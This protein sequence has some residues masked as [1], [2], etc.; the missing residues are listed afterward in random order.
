MARQTIN[1][2]SSPNKGDGDPLRLAFNKINENFDELYQTTDTIA[3]QTNFEGNFTG[4]V[5]ADNSTKLV[6]GDIGLIVG[7][8]VNNSV[9]TGDLQVNTIVA[10]DSTIFFDS[11][12]DTLT[13]TTGIFSTVAG[14]LTGQVSDISNHS[15]TNLSEGTNLY[16]TDERVDDRVSNLIVGGS[17]LTVTYNDTAGTLTFDVSASSTYDSSSFDTDL[18]GKSTSDLSEGTNLYYTTTRAN[19]AIDAR[20][21]NAFVS[22]LGSLSRNGLAIGDVKLSAVD[23]ALGDYV[24]LDGAA[25]STAT[26]PDLAPLMT[27]LPPSY[28]EVTGTPTLADTGRGIFADADYVYIAHSGS[29][30]LTI[31]NRSDFTVVG[32]TPSLPSYGRGVFADADYVYIAHSGSPFLTILNRADFTVVSG[33]PVLPSDGNS[34][35]ADADYVYIAHDD[36]PYLT[37]LNFLDNGFEVPTVASPDPV[38]EYRI[39][40]L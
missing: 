11:A 35:F 13:V 40:A 29:P 30:Y 2:G 1:I 22:A 16:Y 9:S 23:L 14:D 6:D 34:I 8:V 12:S 21:D 20:V 38:L 32:G 24:R 4:S 31:L 18:A 19:S 3:G 37:I 36:S 33:T 27:A 26:Y 28:T 10:D 25:Y 17:N 5:F 15:T 7:D 39:R